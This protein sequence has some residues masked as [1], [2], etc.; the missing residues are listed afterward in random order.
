MAVLSLGSFA[1]GSRDAGER[2][3]TAF[4]ISQLTAAGV[5][6]ANGGAWLQPLALEVG[7]CGARLTVRAADASVMDLSGDVAMV[8]ASSRSSRGPGRTRRRLRRRAKCG[9]R[10]GQP[11]LRRAALYRPTSQAPA[12]AADD[13]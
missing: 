7:G 3:T 11:S 1:G 5:A 12:A 9:G 8:A 2:L 13:A 10:R 4:I 6:P